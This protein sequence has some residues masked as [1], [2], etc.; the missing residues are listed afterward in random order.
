VIVKALTDRRPAAR[1][2]VGRDARQVSMLRHLPTRL[3]DR[4]LM[5]TLGLRREAFGESAAQRAPGA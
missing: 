3:R 1:Y 5:S 2:V 4:L